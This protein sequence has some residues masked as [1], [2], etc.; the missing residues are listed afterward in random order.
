[1][2]AW[3]LIFFTIKSC[4]LVS[5][6]PEWFGLYSTQKIVFI[7]AAISLVIVFFKVV[8]RLK[9]SLRI[10]S[11]WKNLASKYLIV[12]F[13]ISLLSA[14]PFLNQGVSIGEDI[15]G[16]V[17]SSLQWTQGEVDAPNII[18]GPNRLDLSSDQSKWSLR[19]PGAS[20]LPLPGL[21]IG[22]SLGASIQ[23]GL[24]TCSL[25]GGLGW[26]QIFKKFNV[27]K[28]VILLAAILM[29]IMAGTSI[30]L[31]STANVILFG[32]VP[33]FIL[34]AYAI[35]SKFSRNKQSFRL[36]TTL[37]FFLLLIG[38]FAWIKLAGLIVA[39]TIGACLF[40]I[41]L[42]EFNQ[43]KKRIYIIFF[44]IAGIFFWIPFFGLEQTNF[45]MTGMTADEL[46]GKNDSDIQAPLF[47]KYWGNSTKGSWLAW[48]FAAAPGYAL[49]GK[50]IAHE[51]KN[52]GLQFNQFNKWIDRNGINEHVLLSGM[53]GFILT[54]LLLIDMKRS[55]QV[56]K[57][58]EKVSL[59]CFFTLP[60]I[61][62]CI[63]AHRYEWNYLLYHAHTIEFWLIYA[64]PTF[65]VYS[66]ATKLRLNTSILLGVIIALPLGKKVEYIVYN[67]SNEEFKYISRTEAKLALKPG[68]YSKA[69]DYIEEDSKNPLDVVYFLP[70]GDMGDLILRT[71]MRSMATHFATDNFPNISKLE[72]S[73]KLNIYC[74]Y[75]TS[76]RK[77]QRFINSFEKKFPQSVSQK[78]IY[79]S[80][81]TVMKIEL[82]P[83]NLITQDS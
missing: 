17:K 55:W 80:E 14:I 25:V 81:I 8:E 48:S 54:I 7:F 33:W 45:A 3:W 52:F 53:I 12:F 73:Q 16:Q 42:K 32:L 10:F 57:I 5:K 64:I 36:Y 24:F 31:Y 4:L 2:P 77:N 51:V 23:I 22:L 71:K 37:T 13:T 43:N 65:L 70:R 72:T 68:L 63:L 66:S 20:F 82:M 41:L 29:G 46:Y 6:S 69:I 18:K 49:P 61:G 75:D 40:F 59:V 15:S 28:T 27:D 50:S 60:F 44:G 38:C 78:I 47:G 34:L 35:A 1:M 76:I 74:A 21:L 62:L 83:R 11:F 67:Y 39:G 56:I 9:I 58:Y 79:S 19:P 30:P 26:L